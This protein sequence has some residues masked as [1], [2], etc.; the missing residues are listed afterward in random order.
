MTMTHKQT[1]WRVSVTS[2][3]LLHSDDND[4]QT[5]KMACIGDF[6]RAA[7]L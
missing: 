2:Y 5:D 4:T 7:A 3:E 1:R 6:L